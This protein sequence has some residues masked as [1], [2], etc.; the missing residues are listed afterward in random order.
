MDFKDFI[1]PVTGGCLLFL[2]VWISNR[3]QRHEFYS[4]A[5]NPTLLPNIAIQ[6]NDFENSVE[7]ERIDF[8]YDTQKNVL[9][10][11]K[12]SYNALMLGNAMDTDKY[13][14]FY[15]YKAVAQS[16]TTNTITIYCLNK[17]KSP[18][19]IEFVN[20]SET[21]KTILL[22]ANLPKGSMGKDA[23]WNHDIICLE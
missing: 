2:W 20:P 4:L 11:E 22:N 18:N 12:Y 17:H 14:T 6:T 23:M 9:I 1:L 21:I 19:T 7:E 13:R 3:R 16:Q 15:S 10:W 5:P 8:H